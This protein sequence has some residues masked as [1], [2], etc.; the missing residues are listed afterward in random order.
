MSLLWSIPIALILFLL[1]A[2]SLRMGW[3]RGRRRMSQQGTDVNEGLGAVDGAIFGLMGLLLAF[4]FTGAAS[5]FDQRRDLIVE[6]VNAI[7]TAWL[8]LDLLEQGARNETR[9]LMRQYLDRRLDV[10]RDVTDPDVVAAAL[11]RVATTQAELW[12][13]LISAI[14]EDRSLPVQTIL[15]AFND[16]FDIA[17]ARRLATE[18]HPPVAIYLMLGLLVLVSAFLA[19]FGQAKASRQSMLHLA[20]FAAV[21]SIS[22]YFILDMEYPR[23][24]LIRV[25]GFDQALVALRASMD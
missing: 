25:D 16:M 1:V 23:L 6:E 20:G 22:I 14:R 4:T 17:E 11:S 21:T 8:R 15:P 7:G 5:R 10:Y 12:G 19:G 2:G 9:E 13:R 24:G 18:M 3:K